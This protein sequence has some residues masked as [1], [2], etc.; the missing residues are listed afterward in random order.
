MTVEQQ[1]TIGYIFIN[2]P[3]GLTSREVINKLQKML[4]KKTK[5]GH[6]GTLDCFAHGLLIIGIGRSATRLFKY[7]M[8]LDKKYWV[9]AKL[10]ELTDTMDR[11]G[12]IVATKSADAV[13]LQQLQTAFDDFPQKY[14]QLPPVFSALKWQGKR[15]SDMARSPDTCDIRLQTILKTKVKPVDIYALNLV[16]FESPFFVFEAHV[17]HGTYIRALAND[18]AQKCSSVA[19]TH[20]LQRTEIGPFKL[21][22]AIALADIKAVEDI[23]QFLIPLNRITTA[24][25]IV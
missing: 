15:L 25:K 8:R 19:T 18:I 23:Q 1:E 17:S 10:G 22:E 21:D 5:I 7:L 12:D 9:R 14:D 2:K 16:S 11:T 13:T 6:A 24:L 20:E 4:P 3:V